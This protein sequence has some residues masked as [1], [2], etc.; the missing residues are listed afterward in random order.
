MIFATLEAYIITGDESYANLAGDIATWFFGNNSA[1]QIMYDHITGKGFDG[2]DSAS[3]IN[4]NSGAESTIEAL[5]SIQAIESNYIAKKAVK[6][7][8]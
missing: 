8:K 1:S 5:L 7:Y 4:Y 2:I 6:N 3:K